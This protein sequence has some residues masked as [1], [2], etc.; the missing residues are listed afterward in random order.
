MVEKKS[1]KRA[2]R[3]LSHAPGRR[4][5]AAGRESAVKRAAG[6]SGRL[7]GT[8]PNSTARADLEGPRPRGRNDRSGT[9]RRNRRRTADAPTALLGSATRSSTFFRRLRA[10]QRRCARRLETVRAR[11]AQSSEQYRLFPRAW[12]VPLQSAQA[13]FRLRN[14]SGSS[15]GDGNPVLRKSPLGVPEVFV[16][17]QRERDPFKQILKDIQKKMALLPGRQA[18]IGPLGRA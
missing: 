14:T 1:I 3:S 10:R 17:V 2:L 8:L 13:H 16:Y 12:K 5:G 11:W 9:G 4:S 7:F 6:R 18:A 15:K